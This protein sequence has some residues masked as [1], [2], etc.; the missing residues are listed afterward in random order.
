[1]TESVDCKSENIR[2]LFARGEE[3]PK[4]KDAHAVEMAIDVIKCDM[5]GISRIVKFL[6]VMGKETVVETLRK[7]R[8]IA[9]QH[10]FVVLKLIHKECDFE[11]ISDEMQQMICLIVRSRTI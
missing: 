11:G 7:I 8:G 9:G 10:G 6:H 2:F 5:K 1:M 3:Q 4:V